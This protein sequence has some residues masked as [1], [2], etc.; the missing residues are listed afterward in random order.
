M[1]TVRFLCLF[2]LAI[3]VVYI[4]IAISAPNTARDLVLISLYLL[5]VAIGR[6][7]LWRATRKEH[8]RRAAQS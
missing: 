3:S 5:S 2:Q 6:Y 8:K 4:G 1:R 7:L